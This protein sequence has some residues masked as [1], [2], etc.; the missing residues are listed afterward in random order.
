MKNKGNT[1]GKTFSD[2]SD[3]DS[4]YISGFLDGDGSIIGSIEPHKEKKFGYRF[5]V[6]IKFSQQTG[7]ISILHYI[8]KKIGV[9]YIRKGKEASEYVVKTQSDVYKLLLKLKPF[10]VLKSKQLE[11]SLSFLKCNI[12]SKE[13]AI[14]VATLAS[15]IS[16]LNL[17]SKSHRKHTLKSF[18]E[19]V[20][21]ND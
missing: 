16:N 20:S 21:R 5:R 18:L 14:K 13:D 2:L 3:V 10:V 1:V 17:R 15:Q 11:L 4:A 9:G 6:I 12:V 19:S 8:K 7:N